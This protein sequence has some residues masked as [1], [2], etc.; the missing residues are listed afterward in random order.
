[1]KAANGSNALLSTVYAA[2]KGAMGEDAVDGDAVE[3][4]FDTY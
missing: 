4:D 2:I 3:D 1:M